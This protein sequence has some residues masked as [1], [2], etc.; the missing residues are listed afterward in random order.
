MLKRKIY[1]HCD[2]LQRLRLAECTIIKEYIPASLSSMST[3]LC[4]CFS[5]EMG[6]FFFCSTVDP[7]PVLVCQLAILL[8]H[9]LT[10]RKIRCIQSCNKFQARLYM[11]LLFIFG[12][13]QSKWISYRLLFKHAFQTRSRVV[14]ALKSA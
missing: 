6:S 4:K 11:K 5:I 1:I 10:L 8:M 12:R 3:N 7:P 14:K 13:P 2:L 9:Y